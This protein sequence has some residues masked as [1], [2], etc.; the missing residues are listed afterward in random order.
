MVPAMRFLIVALFVSILWVVI[1]SGASSA[2]ADVPDYV[3]DM[4]FP[5]IQD[6]SGSEEYSW[7]VQLGDDQELRQVDSQRVQVYYESGHP[8]MT[9]S[10]EA[11]HDATGADVPTTLEAT[12]GD[13]ITLDVHHRAGNPIAGGAPFDYPVLAG[14]GFESGFQPV[15]VQMPPS[16]VLDIEPLNE[17]HCV[18]PLLKGKSLRA[19]RRQL[20][21][22]GCSLG[23]VSRRGASVKSA[24]VIGQS[25]RAGAVL[26][27][28]GSVGIRLGS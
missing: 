19:S 14:P 15:I 1:G 8:A 4:G 20:V 17:D 2:L 21:R 26:K 6:A 23:R 16:E 24:K 13:V 10:A 5:A 11:A 7:R 27:P 3:G 12:E 18:V 22:S 25:P 9:I 28:G